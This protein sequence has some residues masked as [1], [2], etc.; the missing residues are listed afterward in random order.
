M[1]LR[2][3]ALA[4]VAFGLVTLSACSAVDSGGNN[5]GEQSQSGQQPQTPKA[6]PATA[7]HGKAGSRLQPRWRVAEDGA[8]E[9]VGWRDSELNVTCAFSAIDGQVE[10]CVPVF[11]TVTESQPDGFTYFGDNKCT[12]T[13]VTR[14]CDVPGV[15]KS[16][17]AL[18]TTTE[19]PKP[20]GTTPP[21]GQCTTA[22]VTRE[23][24]TLEAYDASASIYRRQGGTGSCV[25]ATRSSVPYS[26]FRRNPVEITKFVA[27]Q[28][29]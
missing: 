14:A 24:S 26:F 13:L 16:G 29:K 1:S 25:I 8:Q 27:A 11:E 6:E 19:T 21:A 17:Y 4:S 15:V 2:I 7:G 20:G 10:R 12:D 3:V 22:T 18:K 5:G 28:T 23:V 9:L